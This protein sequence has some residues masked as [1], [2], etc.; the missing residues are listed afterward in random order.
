MGC[1]TECMT[2]TALPWPASVPAPL[3]APP[4]TDAPSDGPK[5][6]RWIERNC[7]CGEGD[8][9]GERVKLETFQKLF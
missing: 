4:L 5:V 7:V 3:S 2:P 8:H 1:H 6:I 9:F